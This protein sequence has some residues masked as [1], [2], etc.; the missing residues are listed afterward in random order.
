M[1]WEHQILAAVV[2]Q[3]QSKIKH[4]LS[5]PGVSNLLAHQ[6]P[7]GTVEPALHKAV[8]L[9]HV[10]IVQILMEHGANPDQR[11]QVQDTPLH[12]AL[13]LPGLELMVKVL[14]DHGSDVNKQDSDGLTALHLAIDGH[15]PVSIVHRL[16]NAGALVNGIP[17]SGAPCPLHVA[18]LADNLEALKALLCHGASLNL[19]RYVETF[20]GTPLEIC[21]KLK[22]LTAR[23]ASISTG[24]TD[25]AW[26]FSSDAAKS[27][28]H[29]SLLSKSDTV[30]QMVSDTVSP[31][32]WDEYVKRKGTSNY[33]QGWN[34]VDTTRL[35]MKHDAEYQKEYRG[36]LKLLKN[37][38]IELHK[39]FSYWPEPE[40]RSG[41]NIY[42]V[43]SYKLKPGSMYDWGNYWA[44]GIKCRTRVRDDIPYA[45][46]FTQ[47]GKIHTIYHM[48][49]YSD[50]ADRKDCRMDTWTNPEWNEIVANTVPLIK[51]ME[52]RILEPLPF[53]PTQ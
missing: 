49:V 10:E 35:A 7:E 28:G 45:G 3:D 34:D 23:V 42:D 2:D 25:H 29:S 40:K 38:H 19:V 21:H 27:A 26:I 43:R 5:R 8:V 50:L 36:S 31:K 15:S 11:N 41:Q 46:F 1:E 13:R 47:L 44:K 32:N 16:I 30:F 20:H 9:G 33:A 12:T 37:Q 4:I 53:S 14:V 24:N 52:T 48:W 18:V 39:G 6:D 51:N 22:R 17:D